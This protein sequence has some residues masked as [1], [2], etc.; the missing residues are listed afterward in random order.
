MA[1]NP[2]ELVDKLAHFTG[3]CE[4]K[5][6]HYLLQVVLT[7]P[8]PNIIL[9]ILAYHGIPTSYP[10]DD[11]E[12]EWL[13]E[14]RVPRMR[15]PGMVPGGL[16]HQYGTE[17]FTIISSRNARIGDSD[18]NDSDLDG[19]GG[20][21]SLLDGPMG[22]SPFGA[23]FRIVAANSRNK[24]G[25]GMGGDSVN[26]ELEFAGENYVRILYYDD[27]ERTVTSDI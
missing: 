10:D 15:I 7:E 12:D 3:I 27:L 13:S 2:C 6:G 14:N 16:P 21:S 17:S 8:N 4:R 22:D 23:G 26:E 19:P 24:Q 1:R 9:E 20:S 11:G 5:Y 18:E 25:S